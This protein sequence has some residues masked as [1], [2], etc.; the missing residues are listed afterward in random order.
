MI[1][2]HYRHVKFRQLTAPE[3]CQFTAQKPSY[4]NR[5]AK[6]IQRKAFGN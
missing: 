1:D 4:Q 3:S 5:A 6:G 2:L